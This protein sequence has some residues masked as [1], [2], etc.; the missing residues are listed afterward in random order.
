MRVGTDYYLG[1]KPV[2]FFL[3][4]LHRGRPTPARDNTYRSGFSDLA[5]SP[6]ALG[7]IAPDVA[8]AIC[9]VGGDAPDIGNIA[10]DVAKAICDVGA[11]CPAP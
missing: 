8:K 6:I 11:M 4:A 3:F 1:M 7:D 10:P 2:L 5:I 9:D